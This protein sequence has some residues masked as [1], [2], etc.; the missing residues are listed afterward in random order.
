MNPDLTLALETATA[1][2][3]VALFRGTQLIASR[4]VALHER[5]RNG[6]LPAVDECCAAA[7]VSAQDLTRIVCGA[8]PG[9]FTSLRI[10][11]SLAKGIAVSVGCPIFAVSSLI[12][13][14]AAASAGLPKGLYLSVL[15]AHREEFFA[16]PVTI[17]DDR[18]VRQSGARF[19]VAGRDIAR[20]AGERGAR[21]IGPGAEIDATPHATGA[22][23]VLGQ[24]LL[25]GPVPLATW[26]PDYGRA[27]EAQVRWEAAHGLP[28]RA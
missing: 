8:G 26:E 11:A 25:A 24:M 27:P 12:L 1:R 19:I 28:L 23:V 18:G 15:D 16:L 17:G 2:G 21:A 13:T 4:E 10:G 6:L 7:D 5:T 3:S 22:V 14:V 9:S 20:V